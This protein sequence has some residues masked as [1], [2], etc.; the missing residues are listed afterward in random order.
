MKLAAIILSAALAWGPALACTAPPMGELE[1]HL[2]AV[3]AE[4]MK[5]GRGPLRLDPALN[6]AAQA[7][8]CDMTRRRFFS[9]TTPDGIGMMERARRSGAT[10]ICE[11]AENIAMGHRDIPSVM[12]R[13]MH[14]AGHRRNILAGGY[15]LAGFG[16]AEGPH[17]VQLFARA[18]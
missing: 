14:S 15:T 2:A 12:D 8:A 17:W 16:R 5:A 11:L 13:W 7:H 3:N 10:G 4:R 9:H 18:C 1:I 6:A